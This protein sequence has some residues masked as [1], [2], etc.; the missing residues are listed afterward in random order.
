[1]DDRPAFRCFTPESAISTK[2][3]QLQIGAC[4]HVQCSAKTF[5][6]EICMVL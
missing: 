2:I 6:H 1:M 5:A 4:R 3:M